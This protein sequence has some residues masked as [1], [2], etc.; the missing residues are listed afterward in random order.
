M[1]LG[2]TYVCIKISRYENY[3]GIA[4]LYSYIPNPCLEIF[5]VYIQGIS[6]L[7]QEA[8]TLGNKLNYNLKIGVHCKCLQANNR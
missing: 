1:I 6:N 5:S 4:Y 3:I 7:N 8:K 2:N